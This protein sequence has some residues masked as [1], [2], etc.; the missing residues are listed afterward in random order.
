MDNLRFEK[1]MKILSE[2]DG[3]GGDEVISSLEKTAPDLGRYIAEFAFGDI[4]ARDGAGRREYNSGDIA[5]INFLVRLKNTGMPL[6]KIKRYSDLRYKGDS[7]VPERLEILLRH[8]EYVD[9]QRKQWDEYAENLC[10]K[11]ET[12]KNM[13]DM[14]K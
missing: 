9:I 8:K 5:W 14:K 6:R 2:V 10:R 13:I 11:I 1:G 4:Y 7:T 12:Y 3:K